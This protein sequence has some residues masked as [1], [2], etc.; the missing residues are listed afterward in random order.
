MLQ[1]INISKILESL[2]KEDE[3]SS[4]SK[5]LSEIKNARSD[6]VK[7]NNELSSEVKEKFEIELKIFFSKLSL[8]D[9]YDQLEEKL[10]QLT[11]VEHNKGYLRDGDRDLFHELLIEDSQNDKSCLKMIDLVLPSQIEGDDYKSFRPFMINMPRHMLEQSS[12]MMEM[13]KIDS[14]ESQEKADELTQKL[15]H[16]LDTE[17]DK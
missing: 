2:G 15:C 10:T 17:M 3:N 4:V 14:N 9:I 11:G 8:Y 7:M 5:I 13:V 6:F 12:Q 16:I 1:K